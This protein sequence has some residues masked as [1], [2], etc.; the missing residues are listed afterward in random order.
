MD[1][2]DVRGV[3]END[4]WFI[5]MRKSSIRE[6]SIKEGDRRGRD[7]TQSYYSKERTWGE[8]YVGRGL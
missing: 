5:Y 1:V 2:D 6:G 4:K 7:C 3:W 8:R